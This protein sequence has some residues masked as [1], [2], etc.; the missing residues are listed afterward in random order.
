M[1]WTGFLL[2]SLVGVV[3]AVY[4]AKKSP[5]MFSWAS[6]AAGQMW[7]GMRGKA[8]NGVINQQFSQQ[9]KDAAPKRPNH[10]KNHLM[11]LGDR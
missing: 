9:A 1:K 2:G 5:R 11:K 3:G 7:T 10:P 8:L 4:V 6:S